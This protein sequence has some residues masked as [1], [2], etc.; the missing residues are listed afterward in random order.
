MAVEA[1]E[2][3]YQEER[4][5]KL[6]EPNN[7]ILLMQR[8]TAKIQFESTTLIFPLVYSSTDGPHFFCKTFKYI[9]PDLT[10]RRA[11]LTSGRP[12]VALKTG[13]NF[14]GKILV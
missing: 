5:L 13:Q 10:W 12:L 9:G 7:Q 1:W 4:Q 2:V 14:F 6:D 11:F 8:V 3:L